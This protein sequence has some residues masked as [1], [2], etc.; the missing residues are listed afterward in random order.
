MKKALDWI[1]RWG[2]AIGGLAIVLIGAGWLWQR[3]RNALGKVKDRLAVAEATKE[4]AA[5]RAR[6]Q[7]V[8]DRLGEINPMVEELDA[9]IAAQRLL[10]LEAHEVDPGLSDEEVAARLR[11]VLGG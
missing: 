9:E 8:A 6:R 3:Q 1:K 2:A 4:I 7:A 5:L 10:V 11:E